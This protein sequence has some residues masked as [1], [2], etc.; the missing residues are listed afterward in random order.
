MTRFSRTLLLASALAFPLAAGAQQLD[1]VVYGTASRVGLANAAM[2]LAESMGFF[3]EQ[4]IAIETV[5]FDG[6]GVLLPQIANKSITIGYP[7]PDVV[8]LSHDTGKD[9]LPLKFFYNVTRE[10]N[11]EIVVLPDSPIKSL[12]DLKGKSIG[13]ISMSTGN[14]PVTRAMLKSVGLEAGKDVDLV[15]VGQ[16][17]AAVNAFKTR[18]V[19]AFNQFDVVHATIEVQGTPLRRLPMPDD[20][21]RISGNSFATHVD[22][23]RDNPDLLRRFGRAYTMGLLACDANPEGCVRMFWRMHPT[24]KPTGDEAKAVADSVIIMKSNI[25][26]KL[27]PGSG[28][29]RDFGRF[30]PLGWSTNV[31]VL[32]ENGMLKNP[33]VDLSRIY[34]NEFVADFGKFDCAAVLQK[35]KAIK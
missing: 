3:R 14:V 16:G 8:I 17:P 28:C 15:S 29:S 34:T 4:R 26:K 19:D 24:T 27:P 25:A 21:R 18:R 32:M 11:W 33:N 22:L 6:T 35:A 20:I 23:F 9:P 10:Y 2:F 1:K 7:I 31:R 30:D 12:A 13:V 5:Q